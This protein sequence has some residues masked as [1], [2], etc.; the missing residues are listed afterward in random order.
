MY[1][2]TL[3]VTMVTKENTNYDASLELNHSLSMPRLYHIQTY[4]TFVLYPHSY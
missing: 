4:F 1:I 2:L 3:I